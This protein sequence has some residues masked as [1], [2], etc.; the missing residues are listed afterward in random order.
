MTYNRIKSA[1]EEAPVASN[2]L[3]D[4]SN[5]V[6]TLENAKDQLSGIEMN[7]TA[8]EVVVNDLLGS[9]LATIED[10]KEFISDKTAVSEE[11]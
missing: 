7:D 2:P 5:V 4:L 1:T 3:V 6:V 8:D 9:V 10:I 11:E